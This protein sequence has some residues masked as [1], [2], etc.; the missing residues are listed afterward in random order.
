MIIT[1]TALAFGFVCFAASA[2]VAQEYCVSCSEPNA[3]YR[4][5]IADPKP[6]AGQ[7][8]QAACTGALARDGK[9]GQCSIK[10]GVTVFQCDA[11]VKR[12]LLGDLTSP[13]V[14]AQPAAPPAPDPN[15]LPKTLLEAAKRAKEASDEGL[16][17]QGENAGVA[18]DAAGDFILKGLKCV[19]TLFTQCK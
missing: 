5:V 9:H 3:L 7:S 17:K 13:P 18:A 15:A 1:R 11:P 10:T 14:V 8:L 12:V 16:K 19:G 4:C 2:A 6:G